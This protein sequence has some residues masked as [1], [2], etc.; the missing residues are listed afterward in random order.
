[1]EICEYMVWT[2]QPTTMRILMK[3]NNHVI[4]FII[5]IIII[6]INYY[7]IVVDVILGVYFNIYQSSYNIS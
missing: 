6:I 3:F 5:I 7:Y 1:M 4:P 2:I